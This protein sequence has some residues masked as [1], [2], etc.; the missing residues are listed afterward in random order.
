M[1][2]GKYQKMF[3]LFYPECKTSEQ[4]G[5]IFFTHAYIHESCP[6]FL[7]NKTACS[8]RKIWNMSIWILFLNNS[9]I[10]RV[11]HDDKMC[12]IST[13]IAWNLNIESMNVPRKLAGSNITQ[14]TTYII[15][16]SFH[17]IYSSRFIF[18]F[19]DK[20]VINFVTRL[21][22]LDELFFNSQWFN[23]KDEIDDVL[24]EKRE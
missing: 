16:I 15:S 9:H 17:F 7:N 13:V 5:R 2:W 18:F 12:F 8:F 20:V 1:E 3:L 19:F 21:Q 24:M 10:M 14:Q 6:K 22:K 23:F 11:T 4:N